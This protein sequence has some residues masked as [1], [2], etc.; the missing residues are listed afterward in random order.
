MS[1]TV[2]I[3]PGALDYPKG[4]GLLWIYLNWALGLRAL[5]CKVIWLE[6]VA[7]SAPANHIRDNIT[8]LKSRLERYGLVDCLA[9]HSWSD[10]TLPQEITDSCLDLGAVTE[11]DLLLELRYN[12][13][14]QSAS[15][16]PP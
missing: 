6:G 12:T 13:P 16:D 15:E 10:G 14:L 5:G 3:T 4:G 2:C 8:A 7:P 11:A 9:L 1:T